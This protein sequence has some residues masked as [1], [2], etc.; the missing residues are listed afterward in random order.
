M[1]ADTAPRVG[2]GAPVSTRRSAPHFFS[3]TINPQPSTAFKPV[4]NDSMRQLNP[5][6]CR[7]AHAAGSRF[8]GTCRDRGRQ[9]ARQLSPRSVFSCASAS[10]SRGP[11]TT[12]DPA[13]K[14]APTK[15]ENPRAPESFVAKVG[16]TTRQIALA[17]VGHPG[18]VDRGLVVGRVPDLAPWRRNRTR[19]K[20][21]SRRSGVSLIV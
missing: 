11:A 12:C 4:T 7:L 19:A 20:L 17:K 15:R 10:A 1:R 18:L 3:S 2:H 13:K 5:R 21:K 8:S 14:H 6:F 9:I 16:R